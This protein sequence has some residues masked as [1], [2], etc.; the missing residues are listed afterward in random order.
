MAASSSGA[1]F[2]K[3]VDTADSMI[4]HKDE[5]YKAFSWAAA[6]PRRRRQSAGVASRGAVAHC[7]RGVDPRGRGAGRRASHIARRARHRSPHAGW[8]EA[9]MAGALGLKLAGPRVYGETL[10]GDAF[11]GQGRR[12][13]GTARHP[14]G[15]AAL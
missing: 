8:P 3:A 9:T 5:R 10:V 11:M 12:E 4:G 14:A 2:I 6:R 7:G 13:A 1:P 15:A